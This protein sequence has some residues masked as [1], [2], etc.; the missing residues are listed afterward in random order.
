M[1]KLVLLSDQT[2]V[3]V[4]EHTSILRENA[5]HPCRGLF[6][7]GQYAPESFVAVYTKG[8][9]EITP[10][11]RE[12]L[13]KIDYLVAPGGSLEI[14]YYLSEDMYVGGEYIRPLSFFMYEFSLAVGARFKLQQKVV[15]NGICRLCFKKVDRCLPIGDKIERWSFGI[16]SDGRKNSRVNSIIQQ[17]QDMAVPEYEILIC[18]P[19][20]DRHLPVYTRVIDDQDLY[21]DIRPPITA[22]KNRI[23]KKARYNNIV[24]IH[25]R[26]SFSANWYQQIKTYGNHFEVLCIRILD[27]ETQR[28]RVQDWLY[29]SGDL[30]DYR[31]TKGSL[32]P[33][34][35]WRPD[36]YVDGGCLIAKKHILEPIMFNERLHWGEAEDVDLS[37]RL[38]QAGVMINFDAGCHVLTST[39]RHPGEAAEK[40]ALERWKTAIGLR[41]RLAKGLKNRR[42]Q[43]AFESF[44]KKPVH[45]WYQ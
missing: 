7:D 10:F 31:H 36:L 26:I 2:P 11:L 19:A 4:D 17:I 16:V 22:K 5:F 30:L 34:H 45:N 8:V 39:H 29:L 42:Q 13:K 9:L 21:W 27:E 44:R 35:L 18:G 6:Q 23:I 28:C 40:T 24:L 1:S 38:Y 3:S 33:Y 41:T 20:P 12:I 43:K 25:D 14:D 32:L 37:R 15:E